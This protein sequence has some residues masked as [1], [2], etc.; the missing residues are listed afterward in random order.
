MILPPLVFPATLIPGHSFTLGDTS[1]QKK[2][3]SLEKDLKERCFQGAT[4]FNIMT[5]SIMTL[6]IMTLSIMTRSTKGLFA[7]LSINDTQHYSA[8][9]TMLNVVMLTVAF[10]IAMLS[11]VMLSVVMLNVAAPFP[12]LQHLN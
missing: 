1:A 3:F 9:V 4:I 10:F 7:T 2:T 12:M 6:S 5:L 11:V 8:S